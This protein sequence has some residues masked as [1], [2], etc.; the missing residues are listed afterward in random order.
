[1]WLFRK[2]TGDRF[3]EDMLY[4]THFV[5]LN[6][7]PRRSPIVLAIYR[8][9]VNLQYICAI[10]CTNLAA[11]GTSSCGSKGKKKIKH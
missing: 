4:I 6:A 3:N 2:K 7:I 9:Q 10:G 8:H 11:I 1:M 5:G